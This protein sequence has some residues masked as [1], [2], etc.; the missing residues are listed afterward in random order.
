M[1]MFKV[2]PVFDMD[3][4]MLLFAY[5]RTLKK[6]LKGNDSHSKKKSSPCTNSGEIIQ[7]PAFVLQAIHDNN[8][9]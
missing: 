7:L 3:K 8:E 9:K 2:T 5:T 1:L 6:S 4:K